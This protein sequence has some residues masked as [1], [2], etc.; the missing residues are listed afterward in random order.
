MAAEKLFKCNS[1]LDDGG[2]LDIIERLP[3]GVE[4]PSMPEAPQEFFKMIGCKC[5]KINGEIM[6][7]SRK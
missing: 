4:I 6:I 5:N 3:E 2:T 1:P 7:K